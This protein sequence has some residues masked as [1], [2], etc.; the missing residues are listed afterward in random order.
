MDNVEPKFEF[1]ETDDPLVNDMLEHIDKIADAYQ[2]M[3]A[4]TITDIKYREK[5]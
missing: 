1:A 5:E 2:K 3:M 4:V